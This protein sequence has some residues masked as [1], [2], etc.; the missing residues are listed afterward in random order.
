MPCLQDE[1]VKI[2]QTGAIMRHL[3]RKHNLMGRAEMDHVHADMFYEGINDIMS[4]YYELIYGN[5][6]E[7]KSTFVNNYLPDA[8][9]KLENLLKMR[10]DGNGF[11]LGENISYADYALFEMLDVLLILSPTALA[12]FPALKSLHQRLNQR[13]TLQVI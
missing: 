7:K 11:I 5:Y 1:D 3:G 2:V 10:S 6:D 8:L 12:K 13:P 9:D 4:Q